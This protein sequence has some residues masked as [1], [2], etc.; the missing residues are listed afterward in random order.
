[1][2]CNVTTNETFKW[3]GVKEY[4]A[5]LKRKA[6]KERNIRTSGKER[7]GGQGLYFLLQYIY[8]CVS[9]YVSMDVC[10]TCIYYGCM[11]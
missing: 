5:D 10:K 8:L 4:Y 6:S 11:I 7:R 2:S 1:M 3:G 9:L